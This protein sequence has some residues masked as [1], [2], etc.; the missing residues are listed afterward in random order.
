MKS[1]ISTADL[2]AK[3]KVG[4]GASHQCGSDSYGYFICYLDPKTK[5]IGVYTPKQWF[6]N[7]WTDGS[8][9]HE[10]FDST[11]Q[12]EQYFQAFRGKWYKLDK[13]T[14]L[15]IRQYQLFIGQCICYQDPSL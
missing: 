1:R 12:P 9:E 7:D 13:I 14:G 11:R 6:K 8:M 2:F 10:P 5:T 3:A 15:R 4:L